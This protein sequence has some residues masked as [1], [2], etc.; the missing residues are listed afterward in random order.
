MLRRWEWAGK[1]D[2]GRVRITSKGERVW[3][4]ERKGQ[5]VSLNVH[6]ERDA[7]AE[8]AL[9]LRDPAEYVTSRKQA[10]AR[11]AASPRAFRLDGATLDEFS[12]HCEARVR[13]GDLSAPYFKHTLVPY[14][15]AWAKEIGSR[16]LR[17][18]PRAELNSIKA[19]W[20][21][22]EHKR[23]VALKALTAWAREVGKLDRKDDPT[24][25][26]KLPEVKSARPLGER[27][28]PA[29]T[30][31]A[32]YAALTNYTYVPGW[33]DDAPEGEPTAT[34]DLQ[35]V[36]DVFVLRAK[37]GLHHSEIER[38][39]RGEGRIRVLEDEGEIAAVLIFPH[40]RGDA[41][42][43]SVDKQTLAAAQRLQ[44]R[45]K[46]PNRVATSRAAARVV[47]AHPKLEGFT[48]EALRHSFVTLGTRGRVVM[49]RGGSVPIEV[50]SQ[51]AGHRSTATTK[52]H[53]LDE[54]V[55]P[56][57]VLPLALVNADDP[58]IPVPD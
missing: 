38:L 45:G 51:V 12:E 30:I 58:S 6:S 31:E 2:G 4:I 47:E 13:S 16:D 22:A 55:P 9:F 32:F 46:A 37:A 15:Q 11:Q 52:R 56:M 50:L 26:L 35:P 41:H 44:A 20:K 34:V 29:E 7:R 23:V 49:P 43:V 24:F 33:G 39:A 53:Y 5:T 42:A 48:F 21:T 17:D 57:V 8:L 18:V 10:K 1:W 36:R 28:F 25:D 14:L 40:K 19:K 54:F 3:V 27:A